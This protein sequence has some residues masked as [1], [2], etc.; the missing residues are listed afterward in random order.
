[1]T[2]KTINGPKEK[3]VEDLKEVLHDAEALLKH[4]AGELNEQ[5]EAAREKLKDKI[6]DTKVK[7]KELEGIAREKASEALEEADTVIRKHP[8]ETLGISFLAGLVIGV[9]LRGK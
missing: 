9:I 8:Y 7:L 5:A 4:T 2:T 1:M 3:L 6:S